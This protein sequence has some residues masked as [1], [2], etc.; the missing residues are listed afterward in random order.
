MEPTINFNTV[1]DY[2]QFNQH[3][4][5]HPLVS[6]LDFSNADRR[7]GSKMYF[8]LYCAFLKDVKCGDLKYGKQLMITKRVLWYLYLLVKF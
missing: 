6:V 1:D 7:T 2:N 8:N 5:L 4:T 3:E